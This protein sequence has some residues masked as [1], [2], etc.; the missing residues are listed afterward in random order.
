MLGMSPNLDI[1][2]TRMSYPMRF[3][4]V[5]AALFCTFTTVVPSLAEDQAGLDYFEKNVRPLLAQRCYKCH[6]EKSEKKKGGLLLDR[7]AGWVAGGDSGP[8]IV[9]GKPDGSL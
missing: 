5:T 2:P 3:V 6:S 4:F 7:K 9:P 1:P 8:A